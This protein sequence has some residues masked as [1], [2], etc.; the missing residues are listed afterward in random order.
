MNKK[1][2]IGIVSMVLI[3]LCGIGFYF[4]SETSYQKQV[5]VAAS[6]LSSN[7]KKL[8]QIQVE[9]SASYTDDSKQFLKEEVTQEKISSLVEHLEAYEKANKKTDKLLADL[10]KNDQK[11]YQLN[12]NNVSSIKNELQAVQ[13]KLNGKQSVNGLFQKPYLIG[14]ESNQDVIIIDDLS[15]EQLRDVRDIYYQKEVK[16]EQGFEDVLNKGLDLATEQVNQINKTNKLLEVLYKDGKATDQADREK[17]EA[18]KKEVELIKNEKAKKSFNNPLKVIEE[19]VKEREALAEQEKAAAEEV[20]R[21]HE[22]LKEQEVS[23]TETAENQTQ[24]T[25]PVPAPIEEV[26]TV[27]TPNVQPVAPVAPP[28]NS[29]SGGSSNSNSTGGNNIVGNGTTG[30]GSGNTN[31]GNTG[32]TTTP[33]PPQA[34]YALNPYTGSGTFY[35]TYEAAVSAARNNLEANGYMI[36]TEYWSDGTEKY[37][38]EFY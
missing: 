12:V 21:Q 22:T 33:E 25:E 4:L 38:L 31:G 23:L 20:Q 26:P 35:A 24:S 29:G 19:N 34:P 10:R 5:E 15:E 32:N 18:F 28:T 1:V 17:Y 7:E 37:Y 13:R 36:V 14:A 3:T 27:E 8:K 2:Q 9:L 11:K 30:N 6:E 16:E